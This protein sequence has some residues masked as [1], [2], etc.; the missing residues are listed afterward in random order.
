MPPLYLVKTDDTSEKLPDH[1]MTVPH[2]YLQTIKKTYAKFKTH[3]R[4]RS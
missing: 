4:M 2:A 1:H 3:T